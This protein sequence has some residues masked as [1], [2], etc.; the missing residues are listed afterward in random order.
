LI[1]IRTA[2]GTLLSS[3]S[4]GGTIGNDAKILFQSPENGTFFVGIAAAGNASIGSYTIKVGGIADDYAGSSLTDGLITPD[5][6]ATYGLINTREDTD[7]F[8][9]G[10][11]ADQT[12]KVALAGDTR[13]EAVLDP[14]SDTYLTV[15]DSSGKYYASMMTPMVKVIRN[16]FLPQHPQASTLLKPRARLAYSQVVIKSV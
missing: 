1:E 7:W 16:C 9:V 14:L 5:G 3:N 6:S 2:A 11:S 10:L 13:S 8:K 12:Y 4:G 15:R